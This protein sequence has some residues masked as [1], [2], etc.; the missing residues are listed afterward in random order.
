MKER[1]P[2]TKIRVLI[3]DDSPFSR[4]LIASSLDPAWF[5]VVGFADG[6]RSAIEN[7]RTLLPDVVTMDITMPEI[8]GLEA[9]RRIV[10]E[11]P[12]ARIVILSSMRDDELL[13]KAARN[14]AVDFLQKPFEPDQ[15]MQ[16][17]KTA[18]DAVVA[19]DDFRNRYPADFIAAFLNLL[20]RFSI[21]T[22]VRPTGDEPRITSSGLSVLVGV[23]GQFSGRLILDLAADTAETLA[24]RL[25]K[26]PP[27][28][29]DQTNEVI[30]E[31]A[32]IVAG[33][34]ASRLNKE[35]R[36][37]FLRVSPPGIFT[38]NN[39]AIVNVNLDLHRWLVTTPFGEI[40]LSV[41]FKKEAQ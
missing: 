29:S 24:T 21:D 40:L 41:G 32:N 31:L 23:T 19:H 39:F 18:C 37:A 14:G 1:E 34:A 33:N 36:G 35:F 3:V 6:Y 9:T 38:G 26:Q 13:A 8:D 16:A 4:H 12:G 17:L 27:R 28:N 7:Y 11:E 22:D 2:I 20:K 10:A 5:E 30:A 15:L 25:L